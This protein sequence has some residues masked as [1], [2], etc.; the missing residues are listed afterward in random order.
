MPSA[1]LSTTLQCNILGGK[2][3]TDTLKPARI[4]FQHQF[5]FLR[6]V[7]VLWVYYTVECNVKRRR[8]VISKMIHAA[9]LSYGYHIEHAIYKIYRANSQRPV[10]KKQPSYNITF[11]IEYKPEFD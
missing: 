10:R 2:L 4:L 11:E 3:S 7:R 9:K 1:H 5:W 8:F 6:G